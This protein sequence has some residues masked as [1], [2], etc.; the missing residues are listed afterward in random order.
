L[1]ADGATVPIMYAMK[2]RDQDG[3]SSTSIV[4][5]MRAQSG[6]Q[7][8]ALQCFFPRTPSAASVTF[9]RWASIVGSTVSLEVRP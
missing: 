9:G 4:F 7:L 8:G 2:A 1:N 6:S 5:E 3:Q